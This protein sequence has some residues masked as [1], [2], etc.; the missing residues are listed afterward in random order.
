M[1]YFS[2]YVLIRF[3]LRYVK[4]IQMEYSISSNTNGIVIDFIKN[5]LHNQKYL[6]K[7]SFERCILISYIGQ[8][9][10]SRHC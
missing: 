2:L 4:I 5:S 6:Q 7:K 8:P 9:I 1:F 10:T 3:A